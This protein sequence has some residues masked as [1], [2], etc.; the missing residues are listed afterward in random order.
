MGPIHNR[1]APACMGLW[2]TPT[3]VESIVGL[4]CDHRLYRLKKMNFF[5]KQTSVYTS[6][7]KNLTSC[8]AQQLMQKRLLSA[9]S[10]QSYLRRD[11]SAKQQRYNEISIFYWDDMKSIFIFNPLEMTI[12]YNSHANLITWN[13]YSLQL[14]R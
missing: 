8:Y 13:N 9:T 10:C 7:P 5:K 4:I 1:A 14:R 2:C 11:V 3:I 12:H 6:C